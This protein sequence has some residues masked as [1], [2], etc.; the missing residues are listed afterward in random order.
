MPAMTKLMIAFALALALAACG[1]KKQPEP[2][3]PLPAPAE[4][5]P[6]A[7]MTPDECN[8]RGGIVKGDIGDGQVRCDD[9]QE[10][11]GRVDQ[12]IE[13]AVCCAAPAAAP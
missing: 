4:P 8:A 9:G 5:T 7:A 3:E 2:A 11:L 1:G 13:G 10:E 6:G 12:G